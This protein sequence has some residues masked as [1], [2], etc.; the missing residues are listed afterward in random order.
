MTTSQAATDTA[1]CN[2]LIREGLPGCKVLMTPAS[3]SPARI[4]HCDMI[5]FPNAKINLGLYITRRR[6]DGYHD[7]STCFYP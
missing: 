6:D 7:L 1:R 3:I 5:L 2:S 4:I